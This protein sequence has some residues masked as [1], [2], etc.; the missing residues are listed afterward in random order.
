MLKM[1]AL[2]DLLEGE[3]VL[4]V[5]EEVLDEASEDGEH[6][7]DHSESWAVARVVVCIGG[8]V[9]RRTQAK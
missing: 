3:V 8:A 9:S 1:D 2:L 5:E 4:H 7:E 6:S